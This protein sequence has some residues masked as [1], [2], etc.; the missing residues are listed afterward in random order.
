LLAKTLTVPSPRLWRIVVHQH[1]SSTFTVRVWVDGKLLLPD[2][3][4][5]PAAAA[6]AYIDEALVD[7]RP[8]DRLS[9]RT[10]GEAGI[11]TF[12]AT[13][14]EIARRWLEERMQRDGATSGTRAAV[15]PDATLDADTPDPKAQS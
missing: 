9:L 4:G 13:E 8:D 2:C 12:R 7:A 1:N 10:Q 5:C 15:D 14:L 11:R 3:A 6:L